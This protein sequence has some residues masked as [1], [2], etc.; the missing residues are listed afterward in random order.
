[1]LRQLFPFA[2][3][4]LSLA[5]CAHVPTIAPVAMDNPANPSAAVGPAFPGTDFLNVAAAV[6][7]SNPIAVTAGAN[8]PG[9]PP[10]V[11]AGKKTLP[12]ATDDMH[13]MNMPGMK[14]NT[15]KNMGG[16]Q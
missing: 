12:T 5:G 16:K 15:S 7:E 2:L 11:H 3:L 4:A 9:A 1:M 8:L 13:G 6:Q 10:S 14:M